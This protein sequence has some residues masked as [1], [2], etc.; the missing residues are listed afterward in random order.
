MSKSQP[1]YFQA[2]LIT[3]KSGV[4]SFTED[5]SAFPSDLSLSSGKGLPLGLSHQDLLYLLHAN[6]TLIAK[7]NGLCWQVVQ[8]SNLVAETLCVCAPWLYTELESGVSRNVQ[9]AQVLVPSPEEKCGRKWLEAGTG[10]KKKKNKK[11][12]K[13]AATEP[14][15]NSASVFFT[16]Y[17]RPCWDDL[18]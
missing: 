8:K 16:S 5:V 15:F 13:C 1:S 4:M 9:C 17:T 10:W 6:S 7:S 3:T 18:R 11:L 12:E 2:R 14:N